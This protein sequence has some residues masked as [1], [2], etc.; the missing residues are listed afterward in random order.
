MKYRDLITL[1]VSIFFILSLI[2]SIG[3]DN[4]VWFLPVL[5]FATLVIVIYKLWL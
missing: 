1:F 2:Y 4:S 5:L 3:V